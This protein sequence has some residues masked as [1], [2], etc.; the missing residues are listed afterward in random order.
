MSNLSEYITVMKKNYGS[1]IFMRSVT[2]NDSKATRYTAWLFTVGLLESHALQEEKPLK[3]VTKLPKKSPLGV[4]K[5]I[6][7][8]LYIHK[9]Y[10]DIL[11]DALLS[12]AKGVINDFEYTIIKHN[13]KTNGL[14]FIDSPDFD[15]SPNPIVGASILIRND[16]TIRKM[17]PLSD[18]W[19]YHHKWLMVK[20]DYEGF[21]VEESKKYSIK[22]MKLKPNKSRIGK[23][24]YWD[25]NIL[26]FLSK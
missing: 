18:P 16:G 23:K 9:K 26:L 1:M 4:G 11:S 21:D 2:K 7:G 6:G 25:K 15:T 5:L 20:D 22:W 19:I 10:E 3:I 12:K 8:C 14:T 24:S 17:S 13:T